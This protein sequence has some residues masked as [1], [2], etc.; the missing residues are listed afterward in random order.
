MREV[1]IGVA[2]GL[3]TAA[4][5][6]MSTSGHAQSTSVQPAPVQATPIQDWV[7]A[8]NARVDRAMIMPA[9]EHGMVEATFQRGDDGR[10]RAVEVGRGTLSMKRA[11]KLS[12]NRLR[13]LPPLPAG[14][15]GTRIRVRMLM[16]DPADVWGYHTRRRQMLADARTSNLR[17]AQAAQ[18]VR[19]ASL[20]RR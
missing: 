6:I 7:E 2:T 3:A 18:P 5:L 16:G 20:E 11:A 8:V 10:V 1:V 19:V 14:Y 4:A 17:L 15:A 9:G 12:L 13:D